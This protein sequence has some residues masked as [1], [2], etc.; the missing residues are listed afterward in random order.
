MPVPLPLALDGDAR[1][2]GRRARRRCCWSRGCSACCPGCAPRCC[3]PR[4]A[5]RWARAAF[6]R[7]LLQLTKDRAE[8]DAGHMCAFLERP[9]SRMLSP[10]WAQQLDQTAGHPKAAPWV[11]TLALVSKASA[12]GQRGR[13][14]SQWTDSSGGKEPR[15]LRTGPRDLGETTLEEPR[16]STGVQK[17]ALLKVPWALEVRPS[18]C[19][20]RTRAIGG[21][22]LN[23]LGQDGAGDAGFCPQRHR[24]RAVCP[25]QHLPGKWRREEPAPRSSF[26]RR[27]SCSHRGTVVA[28][29]H[30]SALRV[31]WH[32]STPF[33][34]PVVCTWSARGSRVTFPS[35]KL[36]SGPP[37]RNGSGGEKGAGPPGQTLHLL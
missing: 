22:F 23:G 18:S 15:W 4:L 14:S 32:M 31:P 24:E 9:P 10:P 12:T 34:L 20:K 2:S 5:A 37:S 6:L 28:R 8:R 16:P 21:L 17:P 27:G 30:P 13:F 11:G 26:C 35:R 3:S 33:S 29:Q 1:A 7:C 25:A 36:A 19:S